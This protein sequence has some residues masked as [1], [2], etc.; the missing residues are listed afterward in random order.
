VLF[1]LLLSMRV[2]LHRKEYRIGGGN[3]AMTRSVRVHANFAEYVPLARL[4]RSARVA[5]A[6]GPG[7]SAGYS[8]GR[9]GGTFLTFAVP[10]AMALLGVWRFL[11]QAML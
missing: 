8:V 2:I 11:A 7:E 3:E 4:L 5:H 6:T 10:L 9:F 1:Y